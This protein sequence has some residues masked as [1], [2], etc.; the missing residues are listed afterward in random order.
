MP[1]TPGNPLVVQSDKTVLLE[2]QNDLYPEARDALARFAELEKSP[3]YIHTYRITPLSLWNAAA[4]GTD[5][6]EVISSLERFSKYDLPVNLRVDITDII[7]RFGRLK[8]SRQDEFLLLSSTDQALI[9]EIVRHKTLAPLIQSRLDTLN[10][11]DRPRKSG[12]RQ[13]GPH[14]LRLPG[15]GSGRLCNGRDTAFSTTPGLTVWS[16]LVAAPLPA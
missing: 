5:A 15:R 8:L 4:A 9:E 6:Q 1:I 14:Y 3:E 12:S 11:A 13:A 2:V 7:S 10:P 16:R